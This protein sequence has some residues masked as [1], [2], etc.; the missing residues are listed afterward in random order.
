MKPFFPKESYLF[1]LKIQ[2]LVM[3]LL[4]V[5]NFLS[6]NKT[7]TDKTLYLAGIFIC[8]I[9]FSIGLYRIIILKKKK[10]KKISD[11]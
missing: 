8:S 9:G 7:P 1:V 6:W 5:T 4:V 10:A 3:G 11:K 2:T